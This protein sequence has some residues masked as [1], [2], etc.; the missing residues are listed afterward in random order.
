MPDPALANRYAGA[1]FASAAKRDAVDKIE[2][3]LGAAVALLR[4]NRELHAFM[5]SPFSRESTLSTKR[6]SRKHSPI[7]T[8][9][10]HVS[11]FASPRDREMSTISSDSSPG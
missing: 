8:R 2:A 3:D 4:D 10:S 9:A 11:P 5:H 1:L 6:L 7:L